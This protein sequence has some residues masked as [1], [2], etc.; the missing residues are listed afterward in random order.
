[1][2]L[3]LINRLVD[4]GRVPDPNLDRASTF[5]LD[6][7]EPARAIG[8]QLYD[9]HDLPGMLMGYEHVRAIL[10]GPAARELEL[11]WDGVGSWLG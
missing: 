1:M 7:R 8:Q 2:M 3:E 9:G 4:L 11:A 6:G 10:G 5:L